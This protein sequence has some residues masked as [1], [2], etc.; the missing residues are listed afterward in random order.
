MHNTGQAISHLDYA[1]EICKH[2]QKIILKF[3]HFVIVVGMKNW[4]CAKCPLIRE[5]LNNL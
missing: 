5:G 3:V 1:K 4:M 2:G